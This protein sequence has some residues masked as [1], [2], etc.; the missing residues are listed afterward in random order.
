MLDALSH[1][2]AG[3]TMTLVGFYHS[4][5]D[6]PPAPYIKAEIKTYRRVPMLEQSGS[7]P[8][9]PPVVAEVDGLGVVDGQFKVVDREKFER[10]QAERARDR[11]FLDDHRQ[12][13]L[14]KYPDQW[15]AVHLEEVVAVAATHKELMTRLDALGIRRSGPESRRM[16]TA[17]VPLI[18]TLM[19]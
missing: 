2:A 8:P 14:E 10:R 19:V 9:S 11:Q 16:D 7:I 5:A 18:P 17:P 3:L 4:E 15:V 1:Y 12:E 6:E 13:F